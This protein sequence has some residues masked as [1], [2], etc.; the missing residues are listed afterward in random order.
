MQQNQFT[1]RHNGPNSVAVEEMLEIIGV[2]SLDELIDKTVPTDIR[3]SQPL[4]IEPGIS[5]YQYLQYLRNIAAKN[6]MFRTYIGLGY[7]NGDIAKRLMDYG[8]HAPTVS[9]PVHDTLMVEPT[10][11]ESKTELDRFC[12]AMIAIKKEID[13]IADG[14]YDQADNVLKNA[15]H[16]SKVLLSDSWTKSYSRTKAAFPLKWLE[17]AKFWPSV[18]KID[19]AFGDRNLVCSCPPIENYESVS[20][21]N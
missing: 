14:K 15:P 20:F 16:T 18:G 2:S 11:S 1:K 9:F 13:E 7:Y 3:L 5:E 21:H 12:E 6:K 4:N 17:N 10:E 19:N 8:F